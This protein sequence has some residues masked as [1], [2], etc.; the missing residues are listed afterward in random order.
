MDLAVANQGNV[1]V[2]INQ[3]EIEFLL[4]DVNRD[5]NVNLLDVTPFINV[6]NSGGF[7]AEADLNQDGA[8]DLVDVDLFVA[9]LSDG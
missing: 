2:L 4:G 9:L 7:Q 6:L 3:T 5:C 1:S 8:V